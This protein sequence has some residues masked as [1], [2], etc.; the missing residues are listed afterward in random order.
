M[1]LIIQANYFS[2]TSG[3]EL[4]IMEAEARDSEE[5]TDTDAANRKSL[6]QLVTRPSLHNGPSSSVTHNLL[7][8]SPAQIGR[9]HV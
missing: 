8:E 9:A 1:N 4:E 7:I 6:D 2:V 5:E 3:W